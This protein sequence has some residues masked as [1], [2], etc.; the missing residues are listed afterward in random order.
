MDEAVLSFLI[1][2]NFSVLALLFYCWIKLG[3]EADKVNRIFEEYTKLVIGGKKEFWKSLGAY[4]TENDRMYLDLEGIRLVIF[5]GK[6]EG[7]YIP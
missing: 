7:W 3:K 6:I 1:F 2:V 4:K 5:E